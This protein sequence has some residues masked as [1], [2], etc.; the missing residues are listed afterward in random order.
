[1]VGSAGLRGRV[2]SSLV[3]ASGDPAWVTE[4]AIARYTE[5]ATADFGATLLAFMAMAESHE[6]RSRWREWPS[7]LVGEGRP[8]RRPCARR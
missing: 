3:R 7:V 5:G 6:G 4:E 8:L 2:R 1:M